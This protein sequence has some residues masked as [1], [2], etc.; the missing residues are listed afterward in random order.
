MFEWEQ[1][2]QSA[3][4]DF[5]KILKRF[6]NQSDGEGNDTPNGGRIQAPV[7]STLHPRARIPR[8]VC[9]NATTVEVGSDEEQCNAGPSFW[10]K[11]K[12]PEV[13][14]NEVKCELA[15]KEKQPS[16]RK[17]PERPAETTDVEAND[18]GDNDD[19]EY[20]PSETKTRKNKKPTSGEFIWPLE[21][22][23]AQN[24]CE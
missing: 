8:S 10:D 22:I 14:V 6:S 12:W 7:S 3:T 21:P 16:S 17:I 1:P 2:G 15:A 23:G 13:D 24:P 19:E 11:G 9:V 5:D 18:E 20:I 4:A